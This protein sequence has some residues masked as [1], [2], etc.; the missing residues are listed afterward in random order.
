MRQYALS[1][2][3]SKGLREI[4]IY[5]SDDRIGGSNVGIERIQHLGL[6]PAT[7]MQVVPDEL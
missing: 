2:S 3:V 6:T 1:G 5:P 7:V 4:A